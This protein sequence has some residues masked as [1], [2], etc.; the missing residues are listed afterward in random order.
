MIKTF[1]AAREASPS[2]CAKQT[3]QRV[4]LH[5]VSI[6]SNSNKFYIL[7]FQAGEGDYPYRIY[8]EYGRMGSPP[9]K[10]GRYFHTRM[11]AR[12]EFDRIL[13]SKRKKGYELII[14][15]EEWDDF[16]DIPTETLYQQNPLH[17]TSSLSIYTEWGELSEMQLQRGFVILEEIGAK[18]ENGQQDIMRL[19]NQFY[20]VIPVVFGSRIDRSYLLDSIEKVQAKKEWLKQAIHSL[21]K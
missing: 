1:S 5:Y 10:Y 18:I 15:E 21:S 7:E 11:D 2:F 12:N 19:S 16:S 4:I 13:L 3:E 14:I 20:S 6:I 9:R 17:S 8:T